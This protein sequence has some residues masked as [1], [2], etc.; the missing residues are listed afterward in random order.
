MLRSSREHFIIL[1][2]LVPTSN[3]KTLACFIH[4]IRIHLIVY[5]Q[6]FLLIWFYGLATLNNQCRY[7]FLLQPCWVVTFCLV[8]CS[9]QFNL[10]INLILQFLQ[11]SSKNYQAMT[12]QCK[13]VKRSCWS[14]TSPVCH[15]QMS[16][17]TGR[18]RRAIRKVRAAIHTVRHINVVIL[19]S[20]ERISV[21]MYEVSI[22]MFVGI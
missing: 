21:C 4:F 3:N 16:R 12:S 9:L 13:R 10:P 1:E 15:A 6:L 14:A 5:V 17:G 22:S 7:L 19:L 18:S 2:H 20:V 8:P 11:K